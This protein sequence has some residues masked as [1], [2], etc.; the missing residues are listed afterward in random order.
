MPGLTH[1]NFATNRFRI[2]EMPELIQ[3]PEPV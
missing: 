3:T 2:I 1:E